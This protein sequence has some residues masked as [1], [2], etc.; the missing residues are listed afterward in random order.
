VVTSVAVSLA[1]GKIYFEWIIMGGSAR[2]DFQ[3]PELLCPAS[4]SSCSSGHRFHH[5][6]AKTAQIIIR[7]SASTSQLAQRFFTA[8]V[9]YMACSSASIRPRWK[10][11]RGGVHF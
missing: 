3:F 8:P 2:P 1:G 6:P 9:A 7:S 5:E 11:Q 4:C 10:M